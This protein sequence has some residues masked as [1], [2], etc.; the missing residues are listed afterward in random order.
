MA[1]HEGFLLAL[2]GVFRGSESN[3]GNIAGSPIRLKR[4]KQPLFA[5]SYTPQFI[6][7]L[8]DSQP[9]PSHEGVATG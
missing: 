9:K 1:Q 4:A 8:P 2:K 7:L 6:I 3:K 5:L